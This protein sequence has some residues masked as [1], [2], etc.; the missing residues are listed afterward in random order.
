MHGAGN[1]FIL[2]DNR[3]GKFPRADK[4][5]I[6]DI[7]ARHTGIGCEGVILIEKTNAA[8]FRMRFFNPD[9]SEVEMCGNGARCAAR[10]AFELGAAKENMTIET[11]AGILPALITGELIKIGMIDPSNWRMNL[12]ITACGSTWKGAQVNTGVPHVVVIVENIKPLNVQSVGQVIR[13]HQLFM[14]EG[15]NVNFISI[16]DSHN[17]SIRTYERGVE[18]ETSACGTGATA[19]ALVAAKHG[20][21]SSPVNLHCKGQ[22]TLVVEYSKHDTMIKNVTL[23][24]PARHVFTG[25]VEYIKT[26][27]IRNQIPLTHTRH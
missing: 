10:L 22:T 8:D 21:A 2:F 1:D 3:S 4:K 13:N 25:T 15:T 5:W 26:A 7:S 23:S 17:I 6:A 18:A 20:L 27:R 19:A 11:G 14:P 24:G 16:A 9:G 12:E